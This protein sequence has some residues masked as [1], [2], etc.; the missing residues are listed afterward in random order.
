MKCM[1]DEEKKRLRLLTKGF[2]IGVGRNWRGKEVFGEKR[3]LDREKREK[4]WSVWVRND[5]SQTLNT[6][7]SM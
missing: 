5:S 4:D 1:K 6:Y 3:G 2:E 7:R